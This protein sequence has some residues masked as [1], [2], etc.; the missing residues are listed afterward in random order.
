[1]QNLTKDLKSAVIRRLRII[2]IENPVTACTSRYQFGFCASLADLG[3]EVV[4]ANEFNDAA[5]Q[6]WDVINQ[7]LRELKAA[8]VD[9]VPLFPDFPD[10][11][12]NT[13]REAFWTDT[14]YPW[15]HTLKPSKKGSTL[16]G[17]VSLPSWVVFV[18]NWEPTST[19]QIPEA[20]Y[21]GREEQAQR[22]NDDI[23]FLHPL[24]IVTGEKAIRAAVETYVQNV[25][26]AGS[27][28]KEAIRPDFEKMLSFVGVGC[29]DPTRI[30][31]KE[32]LAYL[33]KF[34]WERDDFASVATIVRSPTDIL[35]MFAA[36]TGSDVS[37]AKK[38]AFPRLRKAQRRAVLGAISNCQYMVPDLFRYL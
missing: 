27:S 37:L 28:V 30:T 2:P 14:F 17:M 5:M 4:N 33:M 1:M 12:R 6:D 20:F 13:L 3:Y 9:H 34:F 11:P 31:Y 24:E 23:G 7:T 19:P 32:N 25:L 18:P 16:W 21:A 8:H 38:I 36:L 35:R 10:V 15:L 29:I 26:Y 22:L